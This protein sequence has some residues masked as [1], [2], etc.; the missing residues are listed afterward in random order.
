[1]FGEFDVGQLTGM[2]FAVCDDAL[3]HESYDP[4]RFPEV[5]A[6]AQCYGQST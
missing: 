5:L 3:I 6:P 2:A 1:M 4:A